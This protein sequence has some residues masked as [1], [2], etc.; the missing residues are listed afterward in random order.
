MD[1][2][3]KCKLIFLIFIK[4]HFCFGCRCQLIVKR[5]IDCGHCFDAGWE[6]FNA[7][8]IWGAKW[9]GFF[10]RKKKEK[11]EK[12]KINFHDYEPATHNF[13]IEFS[14]RSPKARNERW[15][16]SLCGIF[17]VPFSLYFFFALSC[18][19]TKNIC[20]KKSWKRTEKSWKRKLKKFIRPLS[21]KLLNQRCVWLQGD[22]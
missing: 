22:R 19:S 7:K 10:F 2:C 6:D 20:I 13:H 5:V 11:K 21:K 12:R 18:M 4:H 14:F 16:V 3:Q 8:N 15:W 9:F 1:P 17:F